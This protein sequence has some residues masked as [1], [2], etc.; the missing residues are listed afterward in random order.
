RKKVWPG[1]AAGRASAQEV[2]LHGGEAVVTHRDGIGHH[3]GDAALALARDAA[4]RL[5]ARPVLDVEMRGVGL[6]RAP[7]FQWVVAAEDE[8]RRIVRRLERRTL[9]LREQIGDALRRVA[10]DAVFILME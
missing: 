6:G 1:D 7:A 8:V 4:V 2:R 5:A 10:V 9:N 3:V